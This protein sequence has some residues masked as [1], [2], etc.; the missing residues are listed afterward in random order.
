MLER[1]R[2]Q[3]QLSE[4]ALFIKERQNQLQ[5]NRM[6]VT[7]A[8]EQSAEEERLATDAQMDQLLGPLDGDQEGLEPLGLDALGHN[9]EP[10][11]M[12]SSKQ[13]GFGSENSKQFMEN[14][15]NESPGKYLE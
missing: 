6:R 1:V 8:A 11:S 9:F 5:L 14:Q 7:Y 3:K 4:N 15:D 2:L 10:L 13:G 12:R